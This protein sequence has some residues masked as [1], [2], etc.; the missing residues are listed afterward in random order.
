MPGPPPEVT[1]KRWCSDAERLRPLGDQPRQLARL[2]VIA[3][4][5]HRLAPTRQVRVAARPGPRAE[6]A[7]EPLERLFGAFTA[8]DAR[9][10]EEDHGVLDVLRLESTERFEILGEDAERAGFFAVEEF[11][12]GVRQR[13]RMHHRIID[14]GRDQG[15]AGAGQRA[16]EVA[17]RAMQSE[18]FT[19]SRAR[20]SGSSMSRVRGRD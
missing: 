5:L 4:P 9:R 17:T 10:A 3:G 6:A 19:R 12:I 11:R 2:L 20:A 18:A 1:T 8:V 7:F 13:L 14:Q 15:G 16:G